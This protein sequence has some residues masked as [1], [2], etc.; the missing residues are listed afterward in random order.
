MVFRIPRREQFPF[1]KG[2]PQVDPSID[3]K[4]LLPGCPKPDTIPS[5]NHPQWLE[6]SQDALAMY[7]PDEEVLGLMYRKDNQIVETFAAPI[8]V[9]NW[10]EILNFRTSSDSFPLAITYCP[11]CQT[12]TGLNRQLPDDI[13]DLG[14]S[15]LLYNSAL[16]MFDRTTNSLFSQVWSKGIVGQ[17][18]GQSIPQLPLI[19]TSLQAWLETYPNSRVLSKQN[20]HQMYLVR[21]MYNRYPYA[22]YYHSEDVQ[23]PISS[24]QDTK[25]HPKELVYVIQDS[26]NQSWIIPRGKL[27][28]QSVQV[29]DEI[30]S[31]PHAGGH[32]FFQGSTNDVGNEIRIVWNQWLP[33]LIAFYFAARAY[34]PS[35]RIFK[36]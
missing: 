15:C 4:D 21:G 22:D 27:T 26:S 3:I 12:A 8:R 6:N 19:Q 16:V 7:S 35:A 9:L 23:F 20:E 30:F 29:A 10:H 2:N 28:K 17:F 1:F 13:L 31:M 5:I 25:E 18:A 34:F 32:L 24:V 36:E 11:L 33:S 14:V